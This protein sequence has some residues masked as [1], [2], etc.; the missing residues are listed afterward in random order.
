AE[1]TPV[2]AN[3][4][5]QLDPFRGAVL[6]TTAPSDASA[7]R[8][9]RSRL[10]FLHTGEALGLFGQ[11]LAGLASLGAVVLVWTGLALSWRRFFRRRRTATGVKEY[12]SASAGD[13]LP[14]LIERSVIAG[15]DGSVKP[16]RAVVASS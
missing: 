3:H 5:L 6:Q 14:E 13:A 7:G 11:I 15:C 16:S 8:R 2:N 1:E 9:L 12:L 4:Q 10:R